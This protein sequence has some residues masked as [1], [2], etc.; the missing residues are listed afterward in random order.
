MIKAV[1]IECDRGSSLLGSRSGCMSFV[2][3]FFVVRSINLVGI[4]AVRTW[5]KWKEFPK[6][7]PWRS[8]L[9]LNWQPI[10]LVGGQK[11]GTV[12][13]YFTYDF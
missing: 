11:K 7:L 12:I 3:W 9:L 6:I 2:K 1:C 4:R 10:T 13:Q 8:H 5:W